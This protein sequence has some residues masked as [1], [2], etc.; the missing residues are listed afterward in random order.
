[1]A[2]TASVDDAKCDTE[3]NSD[4]I[5]NGD[6]DDDD[7]NA[8]NRCRIQFAKG[9]DFDLDQ[10]IALKTV[11]WMM[12]ETTDRDA[13]SS[14]R[15]DQETNMED[16]GA[17]WLTLNGSE[18]DTDYK[19]QNLGIFERMEM[20][21][22]MSNGTSGSIKDLEQQINSFYFYEVSNWPRA[23]PRQQE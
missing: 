19:Q 1:M 20:A 12:D 17:Q 7:D 21:G 6:E 8:L 9:N 15:F 11:D 22:N 13:F 14:G 16:F 5:A 18:L 3:T 4:E 23:T 10:S 2:T